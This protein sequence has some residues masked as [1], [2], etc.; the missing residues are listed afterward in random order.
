ME[1]RQSESG[2]SSTT[3]GVT[4]T[5]DHARTIV[6]TPAQLQQI[7]QKDPRP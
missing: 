6:L 2:S 5:A 4:G 7:Q 1:H 3:Y